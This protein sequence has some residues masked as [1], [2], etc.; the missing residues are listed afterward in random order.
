VAR[1][2]TKSVGIPCIF[3][4]VAGRAKQYHR[5]IRIRFPL[6]LPKTPYSVKVFRVFRLPFLTFV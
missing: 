2:G 1:G 5:Q 4:L 6:G 3:K